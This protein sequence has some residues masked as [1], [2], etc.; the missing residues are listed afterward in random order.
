MHKQTTYL[1]GL[2]YPGRFIIAGQLKEGD[3]L[4]LVYGLTGRSPASQARRLV[5]KENGIWVEPTDPQVI[6]SGKPELLIY[7]A[8]LYSSSGLVVSNGKHTTDIMSQLEAM[9][10]PLFALVRALKDWK[11]EPDD[12]IF[13]PRISLAFGGGFNLAMSVIR[14]GEFGSVIRNY[15][16]LPLIPG[17]GWLVMTYMGINV[18]PLPSFFGEPISLEMSGRTAEEVAQGVFDSLAPAPGKPDFR[19]ALVALRASVHDG[20]VQEIKIINKHEG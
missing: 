18:D 17:K 1:S 16:E 5:K 20:Q 4:C 19:V 3:E 2:E 8:V 7:P 10:Q 14:R 12:P 15:F 11:Y 13:T 9:R 6:L